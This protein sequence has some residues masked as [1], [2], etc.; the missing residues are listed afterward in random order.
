[1]SKPDDG[2]AAY[3]RFRMRDPRALASLEKQIAQV[4]SQ[5][6]SLQSIV[7]EERATAVLREQGVLFAWA[8]LRAD[9]HQELAALAQQPW[10]E[11]FT[12]AS[13]L[14]RGQAET[15]DLPEWLL[16]TAHP[17]KDHGLRLTARLR[18]GSQ[19][20]LWLRPAVWPMVQVEPRPGAA[21]CVSGLFPALLAGL[22]AEGCLVD[23]VAAC[24]QRFNLDLAS[25]PRDEQPHIEE[26]A[27][28]HYFLQRA[29]WL[30]AA[31]ASTGTSVVDADAAILQLG[32]L[33]RRLFVLDEQRRQLSQQADQERVKLYE[34]EYEMLRNLP[35]VASL[36][37]NGDHVEMRTDTIHI[38]RVCVGRFRVNYDF[39]IRS[40]RMRNETRAL[41]DDGV[42]YDHPHVRRGN[43]CLGNI[44]KPVVDMLVSRD[45]PKLIPLTL[46]FLLSYNP[47]NPYRRLEYWV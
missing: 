28:R 36:A 30:M 29:A 4:E 13:S 35:H 31:D 33:Q 24:A 14:P 7:A 38:Q 11:S 19:L 18:D 44:T 32:D 22:A 39:A 9:A 1:M 40:I 5:I 27:E 37:V 10:F 46:D 16:K 15:L 25:Q 8:R 34:E 23:V 3:V 17:P 26:R 41:R 2:Q 12:Y 47:S 21:T 20:R 43:P 45:L 42:C 6:A